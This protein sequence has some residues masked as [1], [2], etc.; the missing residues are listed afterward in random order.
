MLDQIGSMQ[1]G[2]VEALR[3]NQWSQSQLSL[4]SSKTFSGV[5]A[6]NGDALKTSTSPLDGLC[7]EN[8]RSVVER[9][10]SSGR[11][12]GNIPTSDKPTILSPFSVLYL[13]L[14][15]IFFLH[16]YPH[17]PIYLT[18]LS[19]FFKYHLKNHFQESSSVRT[20]PGFWRLVSFSFVCPMDHVYTCH[21]CCNGAAIA[22]PPH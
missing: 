20:S 15:P 5:M 8:C 21:C 9:G 11:L 7:K 13:Y 14:N 18:S 16:S 4:E 3:M 1:S 12:I 22:P 2:Q 19:S 6:K 10:L 17:T